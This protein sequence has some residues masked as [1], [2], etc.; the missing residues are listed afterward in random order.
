VWRMCDAGAIIIHRVRLKQ[1]HAR[2]AD[3]LLHAI[4]DLSTATMFVCRLV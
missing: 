2:P 4:T 1:W 3:D